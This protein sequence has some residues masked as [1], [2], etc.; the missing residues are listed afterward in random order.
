M[1]R[2]RIILAMLALLVVASAVPAYGADPPSGFQLVKEW[3]VYA[4]D[5]GV[6]WHAG[7]QWQLK[8][9][10][11]VRLQAGNWVPEPAPPPAII[12]IPKDR[13]HCPPGLAKKGCVPPGQR[14]HQRGGPPGHS[15]RN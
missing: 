1:T 2:S 12:G 9:G 13:A 8:D 5:K 4:N 15:R 3:G 7:V 6:F 14:K 10:S 11:W